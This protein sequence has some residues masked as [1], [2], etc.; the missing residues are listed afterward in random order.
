MNE[1][2]WNRIMSKKCKMGYSPHHTPEWWTVRDELTM[3]V[4]R[5]IQYVTSALRYPA[6]ADGDMHKNYRIHEENLKELEKWTEKLHR[7][8]R[9]GQYDEDIA[10]NFLS[11]CYAETV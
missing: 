2:E 11:D 4:I 9:T 5:R 1:K 8:I 3:I 10:D 7:F 6:K